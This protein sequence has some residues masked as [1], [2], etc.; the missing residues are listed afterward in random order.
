MSFQF[1]GK[2]LSI[3]A[4]ALMYEDQQGTLSGM[5][6]STIRAWVDPGMSSY[7]LGSPFAQSVFVTPQSR[8]VSL[9]RRFLG[10]AQHSKRFGS[11]SSDGHR[12]GLIIGATIGS[13]AGA[14]LLSFGVYQLLR[15][16]RKRNRIPRSTELEP[17]RALSSD[18][19]QFPHPAPPRSRS[20]AAPFAAPFDPETRA[21]PPSH[22]IRRSP[23]APSPLRFEATYAREIRTSTGSQFTEHFGDTPSRGQP[24][25]AKSP[26][27]DKPLPRIPDDMPVPDSPRQGSTRIV[28][29]QEGAPQLEITFTPFDAGGVITGAAN[30]PSGHSRT[31]TH[32]LPPGAASP[33]SS[34]GGYRPAEQP[35]S[36]EVHGLEFPSREGRGRG[37]GRRWNSEV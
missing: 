35:S 29:S 6:N 28:Q 13:V 8:T 11:V 36:K 3:S 17:P 18:T 16:R 15:I 19:A 1:N 2:N 24:S 25:R 27:G 26:L 12:R 34:V 21:T 20:P 23:Q 22:N 33:V 7:L 14:A 31:A 4:Q 10:A 30:Q 37:A 9:H 5:C 32:S